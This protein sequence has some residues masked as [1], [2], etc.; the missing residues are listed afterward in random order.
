[1]LP[2]SPS[3]LEQLT[4]WGEAPIPD[5]EAMTANVEVFPLLL[6]EVSPSLTQ[7]SLRYLHQ[8]RADTFSFP[9]L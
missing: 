4:P 7:N 8:V 2:A 5:A 3:G 1:M 6:W 9:S